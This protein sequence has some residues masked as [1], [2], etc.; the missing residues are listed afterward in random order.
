[1]EE[2]KNKKLELA[3]SF[4]YKEDFKKAYEIYNELVEK[5]DDKEAK[6][7]IAEMYFKGK[8]VNQDY[9]KAFKIFKEL[10][11]K[12]NDKDAKS[13]IAIMTKVNEINEIIKANLPNEFPISNE[14]DYKN[15]KEDGITI[16]DNKYIN[17]IPGIPITDKDRE[18]KLLEYTD[19]ALSEKEEE[20]YYKREC[21]SYFARVDTDIEYKGKKY[22]KRVYIS[23][24]TLKERIE[25]GIFDSSMNYITPSELR[26]MGREGL[27]TI[28]EKERGIYKEYDDGTTLVHWS[29]PLANLYYDKKNTSI[30]IKEYLYNIMLKREFTFNPLQFYNSYIAENEF[31]KQGTVDKFLIKILLEKKESNKLT[32]IIYTIQEKQNRI[33]RSDDTKSFIVQGCA[34]SGKTMILLHR[35]S[36][37]KFNNKLPNYDKI[38]IITPSSLFTNFIKDLVKDLN[39]EEI[40]QITIAD[41]YLALNQLYLNMY[42]KIEQIENKFYLTMKEKFKRQFRTENMED[43]HSVLG[44]KIYAIYSEKLVNI[45]EEEYNKLIR[46]INDKIKGTGLD[47]NQEYLTN[48]IYYEQIIKHINAEVEKLEKAVDN[49]R[50]DIQNI[51]TK[52]N[53]INKKEIKL[54]ERKNQILSDIQN[55]FEEYE[56]LKKKKEK[57]LKKGK[58]FFNKT[59]NSFIFQKYQEILKP[60]MK[61]IN[62]LKEI[63]F[64]IEAEMKENLLEKDGETSKLEK[65]QNNN[66][67]LND[68]II[69]YKNIKNYILDNTYFTIDIYEKIQSKIRDKYNIQIDRRNYLKIDL[70]ILLY[71]N[72]IHIG[73]IINGDKLLCIDEAQ[74][75]SLIEYE[76]LNKV[77]NKAVMNLYGDINQSIYYEG[78]ESWEILKNKLKCQ[79]YVLNENYRNPKEITQFCNEKFNYDILEMGLSTRNVEK[80]K[81]NKINEIINK[82]IKEGKNIAIISK[83]NLGEIIDNQLVRY[84]NVEETKGFE[85]NTVIVNDKAM[86]ENEK[87]VAYTRALSE[88]YILTD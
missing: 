30:K 5:Y 31:Y 51:N 42:N 59:R 57:E 68:K 69:K 74:D 78:I 75:Y 19:M 1:M 2:E 34:G 33:I 6:L 11:E 41:Y 72:Y 77:N 13:Y 45:I 17:D 43:D 12:Y 18:I 67:L 63:Q 28:E 44:N 48:K 37:L 3:R 70:L 66:K 24:D 83:E 54:E 76:I 22:Y 79:I 27:I 35:L 46:T 82:K 7:C 86:S 52:L 49:N 4:Y 53:N 64:E 25:K 60:K 73:E 55:N 71:I 20:E 10:V 32:N 38:K 36:Y 15:N 62:I 85:Y 84:C 21:N 26:E 56:K 81:K 65:Y 29:K 8:G 16:E 14:N 40:Q 9:I 61:E 87:Y 50:L 88:L 58:I 47:T 80:I 39:V 23:E